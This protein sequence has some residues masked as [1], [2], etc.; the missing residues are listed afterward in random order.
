MKQTKYTGTF[1]SDGGDSYSI[2]VSCFGFIQAFF[3]LTAKAIESGMH[4]QLS[5]IRHEDTTSVKVDDIIKVGE[6]LT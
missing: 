3:L 4:Y 6:L 2:T 5:V 1:E